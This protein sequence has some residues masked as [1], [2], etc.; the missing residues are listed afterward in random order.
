MSRSADC[1]S[2]LSA[3]PSEKSSCYPQADKFDDITLYIDSSKNFEKAFL[4][5]DSSATHVSDKYVDFRKTTAGKLSD[6][7]REISEKP[8]K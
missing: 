6:H 2:L 7:L 5:D 3:N 4:H 1:T 8:P